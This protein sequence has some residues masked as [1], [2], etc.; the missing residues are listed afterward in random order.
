VRHHDLFGSIWALSLAFSPASFGQ[1]AQDEPIVAGDSAASA[2]PVR[3]SG[4][5]DVGV[6]KVQNNGRGFIF[7]T[8]GGFSSR[9]PG[10]AW[11]LLG[12]PWST[13]INSRGEPADTGGSFA[14]TH[15]PVASN[16]ALTFLINELN[17]D[18][19]AT[20]FPSI[21]AFASVDFLP[22][23]G[24]RGSLGDFFDLD[25]AYVDWTPFD[26]LDIT[27]SA[28]KF[29]PVFGREYRLGDSPDRP[30]IVP[31]LLFRY[32]GGHPLGIKARGKFLNQRLVIAAAVL[33]GSSFIES[34]NFADDVDRND[35]K[36][37]SGRVSFDVP[38]PFWN[39]HVDLGLSGE[40][41]AQGRQTDSSII[42]WQWGFDAYIEVKRLELRG[43]FV[44]GIAPGGGLDEADSLDYR[45]FFIEGFFRILPALGVLARYEE[46]HAVHRRAAEFVYLVDVARVVVGIR[47]DPISQ[48]ALKLEYVVNLELHPLPSFPNDVF[49]S[50][51]VVSF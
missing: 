24:L 51:M 33:D 28:G 4:Y 44:R 37:G 36:T 3:V 11:V 7:D 16:G 41:G 35:M 50:S 15:N 48:V 8:T 30:G 19:S 49:T 10:I 46:R 9:Y 23:T 27:F 47:F 14:F 34:M 42:H 5:V 26:D 25:Y 13:A 43:E 6:S 21:F 1:V 31:S 32:V 39:A 40:I 12:D 29:D 38:L 18:F 45:A 2:S 20:P 22:R 17:L